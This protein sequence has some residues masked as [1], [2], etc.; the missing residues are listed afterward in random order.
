MAKK[1]QE[2]QI[3]NKATVPA[4]V[5]MDRMIPKLCTSIQ[6]GLANKFVILSMVYS[7]GPD[8]AAVIERIT[9]DVEHAKNLVKILND[10]VEK[11]L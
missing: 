2:N 9:I 6:V 3:D 4:L 11:A 5:A 8:Q 7:E 10:V 1:S